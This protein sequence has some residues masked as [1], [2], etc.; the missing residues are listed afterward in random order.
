MRGKA[1]WLGVVL[2]TTLASEGLASPQYQLA[3]SQLG[4]RCLTPRGACFLGGPAPMG[5]AC[6][7]PSPQGP[8]QGRVG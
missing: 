3:Q 2:A 5:S 1:F 4:V 8:I 6:F 7:C